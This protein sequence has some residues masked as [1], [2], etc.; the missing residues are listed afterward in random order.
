MNRLRLALPVAF[1]LP[2]LAW[3]DCG[4][5]TFTPASFSG[6]IHPAGA[7]D[8][9]PD[10]D[11]VEIYLNAEVSTWDYGT[12]TDTDVYSYNGVLPGPTINAKVGDRLIVHFCNDLPVETTIH[13]HG[14]ETPADMDG[15]DI[16]QSPVPANGGTFHYDFILNKGGLFWY[17]PHVRTN[18]QVERGL[19]GLLLVSDPSE[20]GLGLPTNEH[21]IVLDDVTLDGSNQIVEPFVGGRESVALEQLNGREGAL[22]LFNG[23]WRP[24]IDMEG[25]V[26][27]RLRMVNAANSRF[28]RMSIPYHPFYRIG[29]DQGLLEETIEIQPADPGNTR[30]VSDPDPT[31]GLLLTPGE[32]AD[33]IFFPVPNPDTSPLRFEWHDMQRGRH[34]VDF[35]P[36]MSVTVAH[37]VPDGTQLQK[38]F[39]FITLTGSSQQASYTPPTTLVDLEPID[40]T[41]A[42]GLMLMLGH[43]IPD[44]NTGEVTFFAQ[45]PGKPFPVL[46]S[47]DVHQLEVEGTYVWEVR[48]L[49]GSHHNFHTHGFSFQHIE[50]EY[51]DLDTPE[52]NYVEPASVLENKDTILLRRR[53]GTVVGRSYSIT[54]LAT[55]I[56]EDS[57]E[58]RVEAFGK[59]P[60]PGKSGGWL[61]HCHLLEH[62]ARGMM[63]FFEVHETRIFSDGFESGDLTAW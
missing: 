56:N 21:L 3:A 28:M 5:S 4:P 50:T 24:N 18:R 41:D 38:G 31:T 57:R 36:D 40:T 30:H 26:P 43:T 27:H 22:Q 49:T 23:I 61:A 45:A 13:W 58:G 51:V 35:N 1:L 2:A 39:A 25:R 7:I 10:P 59:V 52:N 15:S 46:T 9:N 54:R 48:N 33:V 14:V 19:H 12:G 32:R 47:E 11:I 62:S 29:G 60:S 8:I 17:H 20:S 44:W 34:S 55:V 42:P 53:P 16:A 6:T 63:T 37:N